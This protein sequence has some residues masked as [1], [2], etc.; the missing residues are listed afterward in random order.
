MMEDQIM[1][2]FIV[3]EGGEGTGK[4]TQ[5]QR[6]ENRFKKH[7]HNVFLTREPGG[8]ECVLAEKIRTLLKDPAHTEM[9]PE[10]ELFLFLASR[11]QHVRQV[12]LPHIKR[13]EIVISD[14]FHGS[15]FA[16]Q[17]FGRGLFNLE[18]VK[19]INQFATGGLEPHLT[20]LLDIDPHAGIGRIGDRRDG[21]RLDSESMGFHQ[22]V[23]TGFLTLAETR[24]DWAVVNADNN[25]E[26]IHD[27]IWRHIVHKLEL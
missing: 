10:A 26:A 14:R 6:L 15:T 21:D 3:F 9:V 8:T 18:E 4:T 11:A 24:A 7:G 2:Q 27:D 12:I 13:G 25:I 22:K 19:K 1:G 16:Y 20:I 5:I 23:R 17:H